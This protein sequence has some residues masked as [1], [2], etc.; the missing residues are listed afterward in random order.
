MY[1]TVYL[2]KVFAFRKFWYMVDSF[3]M[4]IYYTSNCKSDD[5]KQ[6]FKNNNV[7]SV[8]EWLIRLNILIFINTINVELS[9]YNEQSA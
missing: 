5:Y 4:K 7:F 8:S 1:I 3:F 9:V 6:C 2:Y